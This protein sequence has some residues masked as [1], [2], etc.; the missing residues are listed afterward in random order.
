VL[1][2]E[3]A[4]NPARHDPATRRD[5]VERGWVVATLDFG[6]H[7]RA[8]APWLNPEFVSL[9]RQLPG[10]LGLTSAT[11]NRLFLLPAGYRL[12]CDVPYAE[13]N[14]HVFRLDLWMPAPRR[15][16]PVPL[17]LQFAH[18]N[19]ERMR[20]PNFVRFNDSILDGLA[21]EG[22]AVA[23]ADHPMPHPYNGVHVMPDVVQRARSAIRAL[24]ATARAQRL[25]PGGVVA[26][27]FSRGGA[28]AAFLAVADKT[29]IPAAAVRLHPEEA[30]TV[31]AVVGFSAGRYDLLAAR[32]GMTPAQEQAFVAAWGHPDQH[33]ARWR[34]MGPIAYVTPGDRP[35]LFVVGLADGFARV[36]QSRRMAAAF[37][38]AGVEHVLIEEPGMDHL[39]PT[40]PATLIRLHDFL[41]QHLGAP[42]PAPR[43]D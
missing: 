28:I 5:W 7:P 3:L 20:A 36:P 31:D 15:E 1:L 2:E 10:L 17:V 35:M 33:A 8:R 18:N 37:A 25:E 43:P 16:R 9:R 22:F 27:G 29:E 26:M 6:R 23:M 32:D 14:G 34:R 19:E 42:F 21:T 13:L 39:L 24:R 40:R 11:A 30:D 41:R 38:A 4:V 12:I